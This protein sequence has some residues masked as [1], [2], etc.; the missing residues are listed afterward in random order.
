M[1]KADRNYSD[2]LEA[3]AVNHSRSNRNLLRHY[4]RLEVRWKYALRRENKKKLVGLFAA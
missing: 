2:E 4:A 1:T 3:C